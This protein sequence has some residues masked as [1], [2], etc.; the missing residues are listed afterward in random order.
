M[1]N[2]GLQKKT[3]NDVRDILTGYFDP[4]LGLR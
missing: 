3:W 1:N 2:T 4:L